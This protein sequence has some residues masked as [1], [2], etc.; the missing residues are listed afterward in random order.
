M[1]EREIV[2]ASPLISSVARYLS[3]LYLSRSPEGTGSRNAHTPSTPNLPSVLSHLSPRFAPLC[4]PVYAP[5]AL[6]SNRDSHTVSGSS[7]K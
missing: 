2:L 5:L 3:T 6:V 7:G 1:N 4:S